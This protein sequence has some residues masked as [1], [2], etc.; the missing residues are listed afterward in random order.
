MTDPPGRLWRDEWIAL[1]GPLPDS[2]EI[3]KLDKQAFF[4]S[5]R[6]LGG[7]F[8][9]V[10]LMFPSVLPTRV[11]SMLPCTCTATHALP[12][13]DKPGRGVSTCQV[14]GCP[15]TPLDMP[16]GPATLW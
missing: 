3:A 2:V 15:L 6:G 5:C 10:E 4:S 16:D 9:A 11:A 7:G 8:Q 12:P 14:D 13:L 1:S